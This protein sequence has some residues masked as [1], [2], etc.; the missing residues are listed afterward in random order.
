MR[1]RL[2]I[3]TCL[4]LLN[5]WSYCK[6]LLSVVEIHPFVE[7]EV[8][9]K[10]IY[11]PQKNGSLVTLRC[12]GTAPVVNPKL[13][14][15]I[16]L[17]PAVISFFFNEKPVP[18][19]NCQPSSESRQKL[20]ELVI[21]NLREQDNGKYYCVVRNGYRCTTIGASVPSNPCPGNE[22]F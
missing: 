21:P 13:Y 1:T 4:L 16:L 22:K 12:Q 17:N 5:W 11:I 15:P 3:S 7:L 9:T 2:I 18:V 20:C 6:L 14:N 19:N 8:I 10:E